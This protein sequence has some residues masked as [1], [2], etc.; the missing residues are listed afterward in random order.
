MADVIITA[1]DVEV[2]GSTEGRLVQFGVAVTQGQ[3]VYRSTADNKYYLANCGVSTTARAVG[4]VISNCAI[5]TF[6]Y[7]LGTKNAVINIGGTVAVG[8][9]YVVSDTDGNIM[10][11]TDLTSGQYLTV[12]GYATTAS[13]LV[14]NIT[15]TQISHA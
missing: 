14:I 13:N 11:S 2:V 4:I 12:L 6:G 8:E 7:I 5:N 15:D 1:T 10:P 3:V 9:I